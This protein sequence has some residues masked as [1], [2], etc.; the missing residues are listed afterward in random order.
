M[1]KQ[2]PNMLDMVNIS[3][4]E[5]KKNRNKANSKSPRK[6]TRLR[7]VKFESGTKS[8]WYPIELKFQI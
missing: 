1:M 8:K 3:M 6:Q 7:Q 2:H 5:M 4:Q